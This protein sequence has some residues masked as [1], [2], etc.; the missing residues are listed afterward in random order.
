MKNRTLEGL[1]QEIKTLQ[2]RS[3]TV[4]SN[5][6]IMELN[7][8]YLKQEIKLLKAERRRLV[9]ELENKENPYTN[10]NAMARLL[11]IKK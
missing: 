2:E 7:Y 1:D 5:F 9:K 3:E 10:I 4:V 8:Y 11:G 6:K